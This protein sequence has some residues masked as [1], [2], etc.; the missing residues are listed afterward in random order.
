MSL[1]IE[2]AAADLWAVGGTF[3]ALLCTWC[4]HININ[5]RTSPKVYAIY[6]AW[7]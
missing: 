3:C 4:D 7:I 6:Y 2:L 5:M 1:A